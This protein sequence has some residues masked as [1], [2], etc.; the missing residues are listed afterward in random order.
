M[1][2][3]LI[4]KVR[5]TGYYTLKEALEIAELADKETRQ[6]AHEFKSGKH[7]NYSEI[8]NRLDSII[9]NLMIEGQLLYMLIYCHVQHSLKKLV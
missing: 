8:L 6:L 2:Q 1:D 9:V 5:R 4:H 3:N 7:E